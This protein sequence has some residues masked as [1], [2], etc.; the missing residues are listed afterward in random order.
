Q[1]EAMDSLRD[2]GSGFLR[3]IKE[4]KGIWDALGDAIDRV[5]DKLFD[6]AAE[7]L[8]DQIFGKQGDPAGGS[9]GGAPSSLL[10]GFFGGARAEGG[11]TL[12]GRG[13]LVGEEGP[14]WFVPRTAGTILP[15]PALAGMG[16][17]RFSQ[18]NHFHYAAPPDP[19]TQQQTAARVGF[20]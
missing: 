19:R 3:D 5:A 14:E 15:T 1:I 13:Y 10:D 11:D 12:P 6:L 9:T 4:G 8:M 17:G 20:E 2:A 16:G 18:T 7:N